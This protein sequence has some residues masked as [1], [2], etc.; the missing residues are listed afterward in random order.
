LAKG[1]PSAEKCIEV[2][3]RY[4]DGLATKEELAN[5]AAD[6]PWDTEGV[7]L[8]A[9]ANA[10]AN[11]AALT[12]FS[13]NDATYDAYGATWAAAKAATVTAPRIGAG[14]HAGAVV[15]KWKLYIGWLWE[16]LC[17]WEKNYV[18]EN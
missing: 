14:T 6:L 10:N 5:A 2:A 1:F 4:R 13:A 12:A 3:K 16:E 18:A 9:N 17:E 7:G 8:N 11:D 15:A